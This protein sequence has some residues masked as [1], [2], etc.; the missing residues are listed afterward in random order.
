MLKMGLGVYDIG[1]TSVS[2]KDRTEETILGQA[3]R[4]GISYMPINGLTL[5]ADFSDRLHLGLNIF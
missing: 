1:G 3:F 2:Y 4:L 5:A